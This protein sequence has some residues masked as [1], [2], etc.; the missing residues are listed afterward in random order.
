MF[1]G[2]QASNCMV[3]NSH[4][5]LSHHIE[6]QRS[7]SISIGFVPTMGA[8]HDGHLALMHQALLEN[9]FLVVS[10]FVNPTQF[11]N[12]EDLEKYPRLLDNDL[13]LIQSKL[14]IERVIIYAPTVEDVYGNNTKAQH[15]DYGGLENVMEGAQRP[16]HFDGVGTVLEFLFNAVHPNRAYFGE[17][18]FQQLQIIK[19][20]VEILALDIEIIGCPIHRESSGLAMSSRNGRL[21]AQ[22]FKKAAAIYE[23]LLESKSYFKEHDIPQTISFVRKQIED[24][25]G[26]ELEYF[27][28]ASEDTLVPA[29][30]VEKGKSYRAFIVVHLQGVRLI[31]NIPLD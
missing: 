27:T 11:N 14:P 6:N 7:P 29:H 25:P 9:D 19:K 10:I 2:F 30:T 24:L 1:V 13:A 26:F 21:T 28:I 12:Q 22:N 23:I 18:D 16:G 4:K 20:L 17:K 8:L 31:D 3:F 5:N 15:Y